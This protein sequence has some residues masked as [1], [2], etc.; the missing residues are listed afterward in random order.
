M[1]EWNVGRLLVFCLL[2]FISHAMLQYDHGFDTYSV[3]LNVYLYWNEDTLN[4]KR[5]FCMLLLHNREQQSA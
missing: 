5:P 1:R 2:N 3:Y 4:G